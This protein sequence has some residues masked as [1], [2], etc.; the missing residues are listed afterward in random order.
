ML[1][2]PLPFHLLFQAPVPQTLPG[3]GV[4]PAGPPLGAF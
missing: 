4:V 3:Q 2:P 1:L